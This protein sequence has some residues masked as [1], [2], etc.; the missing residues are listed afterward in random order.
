LLEKATSLALP[1]LA[2]GIEGLDLE[3]VWPLIENR[4]GELDIPVYFYTTYH[5]GQQVEEL[6]T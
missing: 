1:K 5:A 4:L 6:N 3:D 2:T